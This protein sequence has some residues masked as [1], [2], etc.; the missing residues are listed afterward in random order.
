M[1]WFNNENVEKLSNQLAKYNKDFNYYFACLT[2]ANFQIQ[3]LAPHF[4]KASNFVVS[5]ERSLRKHA[6]VVSYIKNAM[7]VNDNIIYSLEEEIKN[8]KEVVTYLSLNEHKPKMDMLVGILKSEVGDI[9]DK[10]AH[11]SAVKAL[12]EFKILHKN[13]ALTNDY[14]LPKNEAILKMRKGLQERLTFKL[15]QLTSNNEKTA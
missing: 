6:K 3:A 13:I 8:I 7:A 5:K 1:N 4:K 12:V 14:I 11:K 10:P 2:T 15:N 9:K